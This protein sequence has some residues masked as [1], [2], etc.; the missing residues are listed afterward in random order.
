MEGYFVRTLGMHRVYNS[1]FMNMLKMEDNAKYRQTIKHVLEFSPEV[2]KRFVNFMNNPDEKTAVEQFGRGDKYFGCSMLLVTMPG[3]PMLGHGQIEG[4]TEKYGM[5]YRRAYWDEQ[6][7]QDMVQRH[8]RD[9]FPLMRQRHLFSG[10]DNFALFDFNA[11]GGWVNENV[12]AYTNGLGRERA[13][14]LYNNA[15]E[16]ASGAIALS[17]PINTAD[18]DNPQLVQRTLAEALAL[19]KGDNIWYTMFDP[20]EKL[21]FLRHSQELFDSGFHTDLDGYQYRVFQDFNKIVD[22][23]GRY[24][25]L[26]TALAGGGTPDVDRALRRLTVEPALAIVRTWMDVSI[27]ARLECAGSDDPQPVPDTELELPENLQARAQALCSMTHRVAEMELKAELKAYVLKTLQELPGSRLSQASYM[28]EVLGTVPGPWS[29]AQELITGDQN[30]SAFD[31]TLV[32]EDL[33]NILR[34]W[35]GHDFAADSTALLARLLASGSPV[36]AEMAL[37]KTDW[38]KDWIE[39]E[40][41]RLY[42]GVNEY[43]G[44]TWLNQEALASLL[45]GF[46]VMVLTEPGEIKSS[47]FVLF[48]K[49]GADIMKAAKKARFEVNSLLK[50]VSPKP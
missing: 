3:L 18:V 26:A 4:F 42:L 46:M 48:M 41:V 39:N 36:I 29:G 13:L 23:D 14:V 33:D 20:V 40:E 5:E 28:A 6:I 30:L 7:D 49:A 2:L 47:S 12:F 21:S 9:I 24:E 35:M 22:H 25:R 27:L 19:E 37:G 10:V 1:A 15:F 50:L 16:S 8:E 17:T 34:E 43:E 31:I 44:N 32:L 45:H 11:E 38:V